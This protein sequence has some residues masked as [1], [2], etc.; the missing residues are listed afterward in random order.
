MSSTKV[1]PYNLIIPSPNKS[2]APSD[3]VEKGS[4][5]LDYIEYPV[6]T[7]RQKYLDNKKGKENT[8][9]SFLYKSL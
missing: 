3:K 5:G 7:I 2:V 1:L 6:V 4:G 9:K 8:K